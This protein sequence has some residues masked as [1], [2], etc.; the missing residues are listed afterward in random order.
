MMAIVP[1]AEDEDEDGVPAD[2]ELIVETL[3]VAVDKAA[4]LPDPAAELP[5]M[6]KEACKITCE[7]CRGKHRG[8]TCGKAKKVRL[9]SAPPASWLPQPGGAFAAAPR[10]RAPS[11]EPDPEVVVWEK[12]EICK[13]GG[14]PDKML[15][16]DSCPD[17]YHTFCLQPPLNRIPEDDWH[18]QTCEALGVRECKLPE[19]SEAEAMEAARV[20]YDTESEF[21]TEGELKMFPIAASRLSPKDWKLSYTTEPPMQSTP[22]V[23]RM[24]F[25]KKRDGKRFVWKPDEFEEDEEEIRKQEELKETE[26]AARV[27]YRKDARVE[28]LFSDGVWYGGGVT[29]VDR[30]KI[31]I[32]F[33]D[34]GSEL[35][36]PLIVD[37]APNKELRLEAKRGAAAARPAEAA[38]PE[39]ATAAAA[40][41]ERQEKKRPGKQGKNAKK[42]P[43]SAYRQGDGIEM[44]Y[45]DGIWYKGSVARV[46]RS[47]LDILFDDGKLETGIPLH[48]DGAPNKELR[49]VSS[50]AQ[51]AAAAAPKPPK[52]SPAASDAAS[53]EK[54]ARLLAKLP[55]RPGQSHLQALSTDDLRFLVRRNGT[56]SHSLNKQP[57]VD[58]LLR[59]IEAG[60]LKP[61]GA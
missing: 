56:P 7:A 1:E 2:V 45:D 34:G 49:L 15:M 40:Q 33:D 55:E 58:A 10:A 16:C 54:Y 32:L 14:H 39:S 24:T 51:P 60:E 18:C 52:P 37:G 44:L 42:K 31:D 46:Y 20:W 29:R 9:S 30:G 59:L 12:C 8:H 22:F 25:A 57:C 38:E 35:A 13:K 5:A 19:L 11:P 28:M 50:S 17:V 3:C 6:W 53:D 21:G 4:A 36:V 48:V 61:A 26:R 43:R 47:N 41:P 23:V 27:T